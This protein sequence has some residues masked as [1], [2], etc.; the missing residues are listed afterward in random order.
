MPRCERIKTSACKLT[1]K[2]STG[3]EICR[4]VSGLEL[5]YLDHELM[6]L[7]DTLRYAAL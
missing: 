6:L 4:V 1:N 5:D 7:H 3:S 2:V